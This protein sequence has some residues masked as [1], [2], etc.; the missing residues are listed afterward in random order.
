MSSFKAGLQSL[1]ALTFLVSLP[2]DSFASNQLPAVKAQQPVQAGATRRA[3]AVLANG[4]YQQC[5][6][7]EPKDLDGAGVCLVFKKTGQQI[8]GYYGYPHSDRFVCLEGTLQ[9]NRI[10][11]KAYIFSWP[12]EEWPNVPEAPFRW[13]EEG[14]LTLQAGKAQPLAG[15]RQEQI[16]L[17]TFDKAVLDVNGFYHYSQPKMVNPAN[18][19][20]KPQTVVSPAQLD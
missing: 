20:R 3:I 5:S 6:K 9:N 4:N 8:A 16:T 15:Q 19:C 14:H 12:G 10:V 13:D 11:G 1:L 18:L 7:P 17:I 2:V